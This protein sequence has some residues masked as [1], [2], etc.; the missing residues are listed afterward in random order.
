MRVEVIN[1]PS[2][3]QLP[4]LLDDDGLPVPMPSEFVLGRRAFG[5]NTL[6]RNLRELTV[7]YDWLGRERIDLWDRISTGKAF[8]EAE[9]CI[10]DRFGIAAI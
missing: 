5:T 1:H 3:D 7:L 9:M 2:G 6:V 10:R 4:I 8:T